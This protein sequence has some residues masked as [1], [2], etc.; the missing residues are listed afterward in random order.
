MQNKGVI[1]FFAILFGLICI[2]QLSFTYFAYRTDS[3]AEK[4][5]TAPIA[6]QIAEELGQ[7]NELKTN[8]FYDSIV[9]VRNR[10]FLD[11][12]GNEVIYNILIRKYTYKECK[13]RELNLGL[14]LRG[15]MNVLMEVSS[16]DVVRAL[17]DYST[18]VFFNEVMT[19]AIARNKVQ[20][21]S[22]FVDV[23]ATVWDEKDKNASMASIFSYTMKEINP[24]STNAEVIKVIKSETGSAFDRTYQILR[25]RI[26]KFG[27]AQPNVQ[28]LGQTE[29]ILVELPGV[30][31]PERVRKLLQGTA[32]LEFWETYEF[33]DIIPAIQQAN[34]YLVSAVR[35]EK[36]HDT[37]QTVAATTTKAKDS[38]TDDLLDRLALSSDSSAGANEALDEAQFK[39]KN[40]LFS[41]M[42]PSIY[43]GEDL[44]QRKGPVVGYSRQK[45]MNEV[46]RLLTLAK[47]KLP[48][49]AKLVWSVKPVQPN[50]DIYALV[51]LKIT[52]RDGRAP[53]GGEVITDA[54]QDIDQRGGVEISMSMN[55]EGARI[56]KNLTGS[57]IGHSVAIVMDN[58]AYSWPTVQAEIS[59]GRSSI[60]G[61][62]SVE[63]GQDLA[64]VLK[65]GKLPAP[66]QI[67]QEAVVGP[68]L[69]HEAINNSLVSFLL[70]F[71][72]V[73]VYLVAFYNRAG[74]VANLALLINVFFMFGVLTSLGAVLTL[75]GIAGIVLTLGMAVDANVIIYERIKEE[76]RAGKSLR[77]SVDD[78][79][80]N[81]YSAII[82]SNVTTLLVGIILL[83]FG[84]GPIQGFATTLSIG[85]LTSLFT[86]IFISRLVFM[87]I[88]KKGR[89]VR[90]SFKF[91]EKFLSKVNFDF[92]GKRKIA[93]IVSI[94]LFVVSIAS[95]STRGFSYG[96]DFSGGRSYVVRFDNVVSTE[97]LRSSLTD[98]FNGDEPEVKTFGP[99]NQ[100]K[101]TT[102]YKINETGNDV[103]QEI[104]SAVYNG[105]KPFFTDTISHEEFATAESGK[106]L[107][108]LSYEVV[109]PTVATDITRSAFIAVFISIIGIF[110]YILIRFRKWQ[111]GVSCA[112]ALMHD[113]IFAMGVFSLFWG[114]LP[115]SLDIDQAF[116]A[117]ILTI[118]GWSVNNSVIIF[119]RIRE[120]MHLYPKRSLFDK[121]NRGMNETLSR[122]VNTTGTTLVVV[123]AMFLFGGEVIRG[124]TF[125]I[126]IGILIGTYS[127]IFVAA[128]LSYDLMKKGEN[129]KQSK[130]A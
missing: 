39:E 65:A 101:I 29:R 52:T 111:F 86:A 92:I 46:D 71:L 59:G 42:M 83:Y 104:L 10:Y 27:V 48:R 9:T 69:G 43:Q 95:I 117:A 67:V 116:I 124:F 109:G 23:F 61:A 14:D 128:P 45:D 47:A 66:A 99:S 75:P 80:K 129:K 4:Y 127:S 20:A 12:V 68:S 60:T 88:L 57:N 114:I 97:D 15:G 49:N 82:D 44:N 11:S 3:K 16:S 126:L 7:G 26:D 54:R 85:I 56:W 13:A 123:L 31:D 79:Y 94:V 38:S 74:W 112:T 40:P 119:D 78:G 120:N 100:V 113:A 55:T 53:L 98:A 51:A 91:S 17:S 24:H 35:L 19:E 106:M 63:E 93:Y 76:L 107:G 18:D 105:T 110:L 70:A 121:M 34:D 62:F 96:I 58:L 41:I 73:L 130:N 28:K 125:C 6:R 72:L 81:A 89:T 50:T 30:K 32:Q 90:F 8:Y 21:N 64:N 84:T 77:M 2:F 118:I 36:T 108:V 87:G 33:L 103:E 5:A 122:T 25:Q 22:N 102:K 37:T 1:K 115:F